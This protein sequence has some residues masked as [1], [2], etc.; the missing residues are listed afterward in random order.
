M[1]ISENT[2]KIITLLASIAEV[3]SQFGNETKGISQYIAAKGEIETINQIIRD[4]TELSIEQKD[5]M[6]KLTGFLSIEIDKRIQMF[7][8]TQIQ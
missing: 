5:G 6:N 4:N 8:N 3:L 2:A 1:P 7:N